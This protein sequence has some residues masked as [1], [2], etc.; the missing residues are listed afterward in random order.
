[1]GNSSQAFAA[2]P[3]L[4][5][6]IVGVSVFQDLERMTLSM[7]D[8]NIDKGIDSPCTCTTKSSKSCGRIFSISIVLVVHQSLGE[9]KHVCGVKFLCVKFVGGVN[10]SHFKAPINNQQ[11]LGG[12]RV[13][14]EKYYLWNNFFSWKPFLAFGLYWKLMTVG[15]LRQQIGSSDFLVN[16]GIGN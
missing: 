13:C 8:E 14:V 10:K 3:T 15:D 6:W 9:N 5:F 1:M 7:L 12:A 11:K 2:R 4:I 16:S